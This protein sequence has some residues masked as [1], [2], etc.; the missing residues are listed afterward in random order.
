MRILIFLFLTNNINNITKYMCMIHDFT[1]PHLEFYYASRS[2]HS[3]LQC[4][5]LLDLII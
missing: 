4:H 2:L 1:L 3:K 5:V